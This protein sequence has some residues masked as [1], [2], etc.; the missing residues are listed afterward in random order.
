MCSMHD[1]YQRVTVFQSLMN[2]QF[3]F[4]LTFL[5]INFKQEGLKI[6]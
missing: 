1:F 4:I 6:K 2:F 5:K 3:Y